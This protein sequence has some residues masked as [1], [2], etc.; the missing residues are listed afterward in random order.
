MIVEQFI[1]DNSLNI[2]QSTEHILFWMKFSSPML[3]RSVFVA[4]PQMI[5]FPVMI[6][7]H[8]SSS[9]T[10]LFQKEK[11]TY[12]VVLN[13]QWLTASDYR[14]I[15]MILGWYQERFNVLSSDILEQ[16]QKDLW[17]MPCISK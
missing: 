9:V 8:F 17:R 15:L 4:D 5:S 16:N 13:K 10:N 14:N 7:I 12:L 6:K 1:R 3:S 2:P 11:K